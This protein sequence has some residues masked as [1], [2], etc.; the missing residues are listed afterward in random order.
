MRSILIG[1]WAAGTVSAQTGEFFE[2]SVRPVFAE[3][4]Q[5]CHNAKVRMG[6]LDLTSA[7][8]V[9]KGAASGAV[10]DRADPG[11]SRLLRAIGYDGAIKMPPSGKL[12]DE[13]IRAIR[14]WVRDGAAWPAGGAVPGATAF[15]SFVP[16]KAPVVPK[17]RN[18]R[19]V[20]NDIDRFLAASWEAARV[21]PAAAAGRLT[22]LRRVTFDLTG[23]PPTPEQGSEFLADQSPQAF[24][25]LVERLLASPRYGERW[26]RH[27]LDVARYADSTGADEDHRYPHAWRYR[28]YVIDAFNRDLPY[29][30]FVTEQIAG[31]R[32]GSIVATGFLALGP[33]LIAERDKVK[34]FYDIVDEQIDVVSRGILGLSISC[35]RCHDHKFDPVST[36]D[37]YSLA[38]IFASTKQLADAESNP[39][40]LY[41]TPL[42]PAEEAR[43]YQEHQA[44]IAALE[45]EIEAVYTKQRQRRAEKLRPRMADYM[46]AAWRVYAKGEKAEPVAGEAGLD[47]IAVQGWVRYLK[48]HGERIAHLDR[49]HAVTESTVGVLAAE[50]Q[51]DYQREAAE[52]RKSTARKYVGDN[53]FFTDVNGA[54]SPF[55]IPE[56]LRDAMASPEAK[57]E[58]ASLRASLD[59]LRRASP[60]E[61]PLAC[62]VAEGKQ[63]RQ[64]VFRRGDH[65]QRGDTVPRAVPAILAV[66]G[67]P[68]FREGSGR[69]E[70]ARWLVSPGNPLTARVMVN[71]IWQWHF[72]EGLVRTPS[73][74]GK[75]GEAPTHPELLDY[76]A[77]RFSESGWSIKAMHRL[78]LSSNAY[79]MRSASS[80]AHEERDPEN[81]L[82]ARF[83]R[84]RLDAEEIR[85][86]LLSFDGALDLTVG[87]ALQKMTEGNEKPF[88]NGR[89]GMD[90]DST[91]RRTVYLPLRR[92]NLPGALALFDFVDSVT[93]AEVRS[94]TN[95]A[96]QALYLMNSPFVTERSASF[97][98]K[99]LSGVPM[100]A[101]RVE[102]AYR[103]VFGRPPQADEI[104]RDLHYIHGFPAGPNSLEAWASYCQALI[105][106]NE[107]IYVR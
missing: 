26:G 13:R 62:A 47:A 20:R 8:G 76:L 42:G 52:R 39:S 23:L 37:Y 15:W 2:R 10:I 5:T 69:L 71:R 31:D 70:L 80:A 3:Q 17:L 100:P 29:D 74:F 78:I 107:F 87:G 72:G 1:I 50:Y 12:S 19:W 38:A 65:N 94:R 66:D 106:S 22:L 56:K 40:K 77:V 45:K 89:L 33:K 63:V 9:A 68:E 86:A 32:T 64:Q 95:V 103:T 82:L 85:D 79:R 60:P 43:R 73:N 46:Q 21:T 91:R 81:R 27:W 41:F 99:L 4:C 28:D 92:S 25:N 98:G 104:E 90:P 57:Q 11:S 6:G 58:L 67:Q 24:E 96:P 93:T 14:S 48:P 53:R 16:P 75:T 51:E 88:T 55:A 18:E 30:R 54:A 7:E 101:A 59:E 36:R 83:P 35:A 97:A 49:W 105:A 102:R 84:R 34:A 44:K 61:P